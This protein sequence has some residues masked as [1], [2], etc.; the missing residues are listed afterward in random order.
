MR[1]IRDVDRHRVQKRLMLPAFTANTLDKLEPMIYEAGIKQL[2]SRLAN[3]AKS[4]ETLDLM[5]TLSRM[6]FV[7]RDV[8]AAAHL[9]T[10]WLV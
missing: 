8:V 2:V 5:D 1:P 9:L 6:T 7:S 10:R 3:Y 4:G